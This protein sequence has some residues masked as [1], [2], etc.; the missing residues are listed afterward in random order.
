M[1][2]TKIQW[3]IQRSSS[4]V[5]NYSTTTYLLVSGWIILLKSVDPGSS[6][7]YYWSLVTRWS[8]LVTGLHNAITGL[9]SD[10]II[11]K[12][13]ISQVFMAVWCRVGLSF[14]YI[15]VHDAITALIFACRLVNSNI[16]ILLKLGK[17][18]LT[19]SHVV[20]EFCRRA[21]AVLK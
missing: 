1:I 2:N 9:T 21:G 5:T 18:L 10:L 14:F 4:W 19:W 13:I 12:A 16:S 7:S 3:S 8:L 11:V 6:S 20:T 17:H 15:R